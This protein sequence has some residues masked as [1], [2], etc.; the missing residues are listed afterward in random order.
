M[1]LSSKNGEIIIEA[2]MHV[3]FTVF[4]T[5]PIIIH[6]SWKSPGKDLNC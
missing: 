6:G 4:F 5:M 2:F 1:F 3:L